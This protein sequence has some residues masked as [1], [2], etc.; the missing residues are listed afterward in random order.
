MKEKKSVSPHTTR[1]QCLYNTQEKIS[2]GPTTARPTKKLPPNHPKPKPNSEHSTR[3]Y[4]RPWDCINPY[5]SYTTSLTSLSQCWSVLDPSVGC[6]GMAID[7]CET[8]EAAR[9]RTIEATGITRFIGLCIT[10]DY[11]FYWG[12]LMEEVAFFH[13]VLLYCSRKKKWSKQQH[14]DKK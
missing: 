10:S 12:E 7:V 13:V 14:N 3:L 9:V 1:R 4:P 2:T 6:M 11:V 8:I 5:L